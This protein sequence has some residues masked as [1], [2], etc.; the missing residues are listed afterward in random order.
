MELVQRSYS[1]STFRP[2]PM[3]EEIRSRNTM[4]VATSWG[5]PEQ[6]RNVIEMLK[7]QMAIHSDI[8]STRLGNYIEELSE[9][10][11]I[12]RAA[13]LFANEQLFLKENSQEYRAA[14][15]VAVISVQKQVLSWVQMG[16]PHLILK[17]Q[18]IGADPIASSPDWAWQ[19]QQDSPLVFKA[20]GLERGCYPNCGSYRLHGGEKLILVSRSALAPRI[21]SLDQVDLDTCGQAL[22]EDH[23]EAPFWLG[24]LK[25]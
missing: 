3:I 23:A 24:I 25:L 8:E 6:A 14:V 15:E 16:S 18:K 11:N 7:D 2:R 9:D 21:Y 22:V 4:I 20:L 12:L 5:E 13:A 17:N 19:L 1:G 10:G